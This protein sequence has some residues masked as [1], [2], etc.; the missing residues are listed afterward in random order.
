M[1]LFVVAAFVFSLSAFILGLLTLL[2]GSTLPG[3]DGGFMEYAA[4]LRVRCIPHFTE[5]ELTQE[6]V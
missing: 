4:I 6:T 5:D 3:Q 2:A 1:R